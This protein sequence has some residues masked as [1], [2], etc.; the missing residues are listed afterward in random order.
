MTYYMSSGTLNPTHSLTHLELSCKCVSLYLTNSYPNQLMPIAYHNPN[1]HCK[2]QV[3]SCSHIAVTFQPGR[4]CSHLHLFICVS[5]CLSVS[6]LT[7]KVGVEFLWNFGENRICLGVILGVGWCSLTG[8]L[9]T[10]CLK[11]W[12]CR[13]LK[14]V[15]S[16]EFYPRVVGRLYYSFLQ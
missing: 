6:K 3:L 15:S 10:I 7:E 4:L 14:L 8:E 12:G 5:V 13:D 11:L 9:F 1:P 2:S 16:K